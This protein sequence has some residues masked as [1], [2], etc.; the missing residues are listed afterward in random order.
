MMKFTRVR[1]KWLNCFLVACYIDLIYVER[2]LL[3]G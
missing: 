3:W 2:N 1:K